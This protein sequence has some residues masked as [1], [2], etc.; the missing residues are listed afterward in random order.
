MNILQEQIRKA[1]LRL[2]NWDPVSSTERAKDS[3][4]AELNSPSKLARRRQFLVESLGDTNKA[5]DFHERIIQGNELQDINYLARGVRAAEAVARIVVRR[6]DGRLYSY[7]SGFLVA[8]GLLLTN[9][10]VL[11]DRQ[12]ALRS[13]AEFRYE[14]DIAGK[15]LDPITFD[16]APDQFF[17]SHEE[18]DF[19][20]VAV[21]EKSER[22]GVALSSFGYL[23][24][25]EALGKV[26][27]GEWLTIVQ[28][29]NGERKQLCIRENQLLQIEKDVL[30]YST[31]TVAGS[32]GSPVFNNDWIIV[33]LHHSGQ[34]MKKDGRIQ[35]IDG[36]D[37]DPQRD[38]EDQIKWIANEG[39]RVSRIVQQLRED[40]PGNPLLA[41]IFTATPADAHRATFA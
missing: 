31:D 15:P 20:L 35:T 23:P 21:A 41:P 4:P 29:P 33:A 2:G 9:H 17:H 27:D 5:R 19:A 14:R 38:S 28:H 11:P 26:V 32:S 37:W 36:R 39:I 40:H 30:W 12:S 24:L 22:N 3:T 16:F 1:E 10:H 8:P 34:P 7:G 25:V 6:S 18:L 13:S